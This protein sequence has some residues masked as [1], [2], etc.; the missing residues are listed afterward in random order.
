MRIS[1]FH[2]SG[3]SVCLKTC[4]IG[5]QAWFQNRFT[6]FLM[7]GSLCLDCIL[8]KTG[9]FAVFFFSYLGDEESPRKRRKRK[10]HKV[11][12]MTEGTLKILT[13]PSFLTLSN[14]YTCV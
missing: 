4:E 8:N 2:E 3:R 9:F 1:L 7:S 13:F 5:Q 6:N 12:G 14:K 10:K 11:H